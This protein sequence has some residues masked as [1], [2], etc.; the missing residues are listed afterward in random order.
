MSVYLRNFSNSMKRREP[1]TIIPL[2]GT[3]LF[4][5]QKRVALFRKYNAILGL[6]AKKS[7]FIQI[8]EFLRK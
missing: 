2:F 1:Q 6:N 5:G 4:I 7:E 3:H 8:K